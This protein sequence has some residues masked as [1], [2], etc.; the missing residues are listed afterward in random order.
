M[1]TLTVHSDLRQ[2]IWSHL[3]GSNDVEEAGFLFAGSHG[4][5]PAITL[6]AVA[7]KPV[8]PDGFAYRSDAYLELTDT[9]RASVIK[10]AH[11]RNAC[12]VEF[13][14][15]TGPWPASFSASD[16]IGFEEFV[17]HIMWRLRR[18]YGAVVVAGD[19][20]DGLI[21][22]PGSVSPTRVSEM[23]V[24]DQRLAATALTRINELEVS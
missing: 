3:T 15:H 20:F 7:W 10:E 24:D 8:P 12:L 21:W 22:T 2:L 14:S 19:T 4:N 16:M 5:P 23:R 9:F 11:E 1:G 13:H 17:P 6:T 18:P